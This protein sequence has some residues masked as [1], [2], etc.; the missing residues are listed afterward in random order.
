MTG[1][2]ELLSAALSRLNLLAVVDI[3]L[4]AAIFFGL[5]RLLRGTTAM[6]LLRGLIIIGI[7]AFI[8]TNVLGLTMFS[9][10]LRNSLIPILVAI[11]ILFQPELRRALER[12]G[13]ARLVGTSTGVGDQQLID[14]LCESV[15]RLSAKRTGALMVLERETGLKDYTETGVPL[16]SV[17]SVELLVTM[18]FP[19]TPLHDGAVIIRENRVVAAGCVLPLTE[20]NSTGIFALGT[21]H[22]AAIGITEG[23]DAIAIVVSEETGIVSIAS[24]GRIVRNLDEGRVR[25]ILGGLQKSATPWRPFWK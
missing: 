17:V 7:T 20:N 19:N 22:R 11:P 9:Y 6:T 8:V 25:R 18:F 23:T 16:D 14:I 13:R 12:L 21:R 2:S 1:W 10:L 4:V 15:E 5:L 24:N 3:L